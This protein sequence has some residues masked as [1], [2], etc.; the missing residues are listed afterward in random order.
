MKIIKEGK[1]MIGTMRVTCKSCEAE[2]E[3]ETSDL[4]QEP[5]EKAT[6][7]S[8]YSFVCPCCWRRQYINFADLSEGI[9]L[10]MAVNKK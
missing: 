6:D 1:K 2:L 8:V 10:D 3:V 9:L 5:I 4:K 7:P